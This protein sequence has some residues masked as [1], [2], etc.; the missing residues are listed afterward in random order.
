MHGESWAGRSMTT[1]ATGIFE[2]IE[3]WYNPIRRHS[4][5]GM[6][7]PVDFEARHTNPDQDH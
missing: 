6:L 5:I 4:S 3:C 1:C 2:W 7:S